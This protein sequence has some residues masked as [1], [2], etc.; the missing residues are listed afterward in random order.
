MRI[1]Q[2]QFKKF[3]LEK[4]ILNGYWNNGS[5]LHAKPNIS[6]TK[7]SKRSTIIQNYIHSFSARKALRSSKPKIK[8]IWYFYTQLFKRLFFYSVSVL[9]SNLD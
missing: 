6:K 4:Y 1:I 9:N 7:G 5:Q 3:T 8:C 2:F